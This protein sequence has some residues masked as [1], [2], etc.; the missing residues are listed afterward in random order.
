M[1][2]DG[3]EMGI[4]L[5]ALIV[6]V[7]EG[8]ILY[9]V[10]VFFFVM[11][12]RPPRS[13][14]F[15]Y[16]T[17]F[18][19]YS[20]YKFLDVVARSRSAVT[21]RVQNTLAQRIEVLTAL[22]AG[23]RDDQDAAERL[24]HEMRIRARLAHSN[25]VTFYT[26]LPIDGQLVMT[27]ELFDA[28]PLSERLQLGPLPW[29]E[30]VAATRQ[31]LAAAAAG[32]DQQ[33]V[34]RDI[35]PANILCGPDGVW[36]LTNY[37]LAY[38]LNN[39]GMAE[40]GSMVGN[41]RYVS[42][43]QVKGSR[44]LD[45]RS[46]IYSIGA[47]L[48]EMLCGR[49]PFDFK[50]QFELMLAHVNQTPLAP[51]Q[52][53]ASLPKFLDAIVLKALAKEAADRYQS[54][55]EFSEALA[56]GCAAQPVVEQ[57]VVEA[58]PVATAPVPAPEPGAAPAPV[59]E[60]DPVAAAQ[61]AAPEPV[62]EAAPVVE[63][64]PVPAAQ[65]AEPEPAAEAAP[66]EPAPVVEAQP[67][68]AVQAA[69]PEPVAEAAP[70]EPAPVVEAQPVAAAQAAEP[71]SAVE[72]P[73]VAEPTSRD[74]EGAVV[75]VAA[76]APTEPE[77]IIETAPVAE[78]QPVAAA[79]V[80]EPESAVEAPPVAEPTSRDREGAVVA[81]AAEAPTEPEPVIETAPVA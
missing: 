23:A 22:P 25:I 18:R 45:R 3:D 16:T 62:A 12:R 69:E 59:V 80:A 9:L 81:V 60:A 40:A 5:V 19:S 66:A 79:Q 28:L 6:M 50:S 51:S 32:H 47:V 35:N 7:D 72:A 53:Q 24:L 1:H 21:Y 63:V 49:P 68:A 65:A 13:T 57:P 41:P 78:T 15:P 34:H 52:V 17:L 26:A 42:P 2:A 37:S 64:E 14:L 70:A 29:Q 54:A 4:Q 43:E 71:E 77:P 76:E 74:R 11:I 44:E 48:Y 20:G 67:V 31:I 61:A 73:P 33:V 46:D 56:A 8:I 27:T 58:Q 38:Q 75:A 39:G 55:P 36:K 10:L 30:A